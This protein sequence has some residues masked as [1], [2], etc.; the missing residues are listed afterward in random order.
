MN[1]I[2]SPLYDSIPVNKTSANQICK[3]Y[4]K[5]HYKYSLYRYYDRSYPIRKGIQPIVFI[6]GSR[7]LYQNIQF[8]GTMVFFLFFF[9]SL[10]IYI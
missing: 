9:F 2:R 5:W 3:N 4:N 8:F 7:G 10:Y 6:P 1:D